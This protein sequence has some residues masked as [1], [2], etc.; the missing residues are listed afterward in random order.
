MT[1]A[2]GAAGRSRGADV[3]SGDASSSDSGD[4][5]RRGG[6][7]FGGWDSGDEARRGGDVRSGLDGSAA[8][9]ASTESGDGSASGGSAMSSG[10]GV[11]AIAARLRGYA[12]KDA[13][14]PSGELL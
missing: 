7:E 3:T 10:A 8:H 9:W 13:A 4:E 14:A 2:S 6:R 1:S 12:R 5:A 11:E